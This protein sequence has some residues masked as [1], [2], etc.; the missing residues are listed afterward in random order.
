ME[1]FRITLTVY[2]D[3]LYAPGFPG[4]WNLE[5]EEVIYASS[6]RSLACLENMVHRKGHGDNSK[7]STMVIYAPDTSSITQVNI[8]DLPIDWNQGSDFGDCQSIGSEWFRKKKSLLLRVPSAVVPD[9]YNYVIHTR[10]LEFSE[11]S[12]IKILPFSFDKRLGYGTP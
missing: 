6:S 3:K 11:V 10:H 7:Y 5:G 4:R 9:E 8:S 2:A 12:L 1:L